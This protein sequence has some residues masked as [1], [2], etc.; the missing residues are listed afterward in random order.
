MKKLIVSLVLVLAACACGSPSPADPGGSPGDES[1]PDEYLGTWHLTSGRGPDGMVPL[2]ED[3]S[4]TLE[5]TGER[6]R[7]SAACN[8]YDGTAKITDSTFDAP[9]FAVTEM[10][11]QANVTASQDAY[12]AALQKVDSISREGETLTLSGPEVALTFDRVPPPPT[13]SLVDTK[14]RLEALVNGR[15][16]EGAVSSA[17]PADLELSNDGTLGGSTGCRELSGEWSERGNEI[18][19]TTFSTEGHCSADKADQ[20]DHVVGVLGDGF[21]VSIDGP[22]LT[23]FRSRGDEGLI[24]RAD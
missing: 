1:P 16:P 21:T 15:G 6:V 17:S 4:I 7:G 13:A 8:S 20:D 5:I 12:L 22:E 14:W 18:L 2:V 3:Y 9:G 10:G 11:C 23:I 19:F 24:Y